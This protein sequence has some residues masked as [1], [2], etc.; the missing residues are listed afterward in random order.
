VCEGCHRLYPL[1]QSVDHFALLGLPRTFDVDA[2]ALHRQFLA[3]SKHVHPDYFGGADEAMRGL[4]TRL[5]AQLNEA[6]R[7]LKD[8][9]LRASYM[10]ETT[11]GPNAAE[12]RNVPPDVLA[13]ALTLR[14]E[15]DE[16]REAG[17]SAE[18]DRIRDRI[19]A[20]RDEYMAQITALAG[21]LPQ[22]AVDERVALRRALNAV[23]YYQNLLDLLW[24]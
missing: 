19:D 11:G 16:A 5:S 24:A 22:A 2:A 8:P 4:A 18:I 1:P 13:E 17:Q 3:I 6:M 14:E 7:V 23:K 20:R 9:L 10:L 21:K 12:D 15:I